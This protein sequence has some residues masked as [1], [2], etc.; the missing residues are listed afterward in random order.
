MGS[1]RKVAAASSKSFAELCL[2]KLQIAASCKQHTTAHH[3][4]PIF[5]QASF[6][7]CALVQLLCPYM[8]PAFFHRLSGWGSLDIVYFVL[9]FLVSA[10][11][12]PAHIVFPTAGASENA[13]T[14]MEILIA[15]CNPFEFIAAPC[16]FAFFL[17]LDSLEQSF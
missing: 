15:F 13:G 9:W 17:I 1:K 2:I 10:L 14:R 12:G 5:T 3:L 7:M 4:T 6:C 8:C 16:S 11:P